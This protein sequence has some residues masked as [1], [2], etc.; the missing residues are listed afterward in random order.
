MSLSKLSSAS[1]SVISGVGEEDSPRL[2]LIVQELMEPEVSLSGNECVVG[3]SSSNPESRS[4]SRID[5][6]FVVFVKLN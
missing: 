1:R 2:F 3:H 4:C 5:H 6:V